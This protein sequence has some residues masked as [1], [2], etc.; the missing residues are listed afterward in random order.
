MDNKAAG[1][2]VLIAHELVVKQRC[3]YY[4]GKDYMNLGFSETKCR[5][6]KNLNSNLPFTQVALKF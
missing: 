2:S 5:V 3:L 1:L 6:R 4:E